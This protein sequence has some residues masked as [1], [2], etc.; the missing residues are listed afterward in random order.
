MLTQS[1]I[2]DEL[3][4][5]EASSSETDA[6]A[7]VRWAVDRYRDRLA[8]A[9]S[10]GIEDTLLLHLVADAAR[11][12]P[13]E[14]RPRAF[15]LDTGRLPEE[16]YQLLESARDRYAIRIE[17]YFPDAAA[18]EAIYRDAGPLSFYASV[19]ARKHCCHVRKVEPLARALSGAE[20]WMTGLRRAQSP[21]RGS[22]ER[23]DLDERGL[24]K[25]S[26]LAHLSDEETWALAKQ[27]DVL[28]H[29]LHRRG[30]PSIGCAPCTRAVQP[31][32]PT[33]AG[34]WWWEDPTLKE[35]GLHTGGQK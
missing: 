33:R 4:E 25:V 26:P 34:R 28:V 12:L 17:T 3:A 9:L 21:T 29:A 35:C 22:T 23:L 19:E 6:E 30:Y 11:S 14:Q 8:L 24:V 10:L 31:G 16:S 5:V 20:A 1:N 13:A 18:V 27:H 15:V 7:T 32:E 2:T